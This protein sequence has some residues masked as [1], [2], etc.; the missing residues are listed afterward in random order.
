LTRERYPDALTI[1][2][3]QGIIDANGLQ[4]AYAV[5]KHEACPMDP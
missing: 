2:T 5:T 4:D 1:A 3:A